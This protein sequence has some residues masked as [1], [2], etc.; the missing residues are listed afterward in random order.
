MKIKTA[1]CFFEQSGTFKN[2]F[3]K[4]GINAVDC[5]ILNNFSE[6]DYK[7][8]LF[9][10]I[11]SAHLKNKSIFDK[12]K[13]DDLIFAF[14]PCTFFSARTQLNARG[15]ASQMKD[16]ELIKKLRYSMNL[17]E[18]SETYYRRLC[19]MIIVCLEKEI[20]LVIENP[21][22]QPHFLTSYFPIKPALVDMNRTERGDNFKKPTQYFFINCKPEHN[23]IFENISKPITKRIEKVT[24]DGDRSRQEMRSMISPVYANRFIREFLLDAKKSAVNREDLFS[25]ATKQERGDKNVL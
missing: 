18:K 14:F 24:S 7:L 22:T 2:E 25:Y 4:L 23:L 15:E 16:W 19:E 1:W 10:E 17:I 9:N 3:K 8:D 13:K 5:D 12:V 11:K 20:R 6:T 21:Y